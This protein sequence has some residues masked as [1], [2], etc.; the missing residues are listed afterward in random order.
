MPR[1][2]CFTF[3]LVLGCTELIAPISGGVVPCASPGDC[4]A[5]ERCH[6]G[7]CLQSTDPR[8]G[9]GRV[10]EELQPGEAGYEACDDGN[11]SDLDAC[12]TLCQLA[13]C[14]DGFARIDLPEG[15]PGAEECDDGNQANTDDCNNA[16]RRSRCGDGIVRSDLDSS[17]SDYEECD[18]DNSIATDSCTN[19]CE[20]AHCGDG[21]VRT[22]RG[23]ED[24]GYEVCDDGNDEDR[25]ACTNGCQIAFCGD[26]I[27]R[28]DLPEG[29]EGSEAC[30]DGDQEDLDD[31]NNNCV[32]TYCGDGVVQLGEA[33]DDGNRIDDDEC[34]VACGVGPIQL[35]ATNSR[36]DANYC[37]RTEDGRIYCWGQNGSGQVGQGDQQER[38]WAHEVPGITTATQ[39][40]SGDGH[41]CVILE[42]GG[43]EC[44][45]QHGYH[46]EQGRG[47]GVNAALPGPILLAPN[48][49][50]PA[51][52]GNGITDE[53]EACDDGNDINTDPCT[54]Q[55]QLNRCGDGWLGPGEA[56]DDGNDDEQDA[57]RSCR[58][59]TCGD[60]IVQEGEACDD[61]DNNSDRS[62]CTTRCTL[63]VCG[64][65][66]R[67]SGDE[68]GGATNE[69]CDDGNHVDTDACLN[70]CTAARC[71]DG[72]RRRDKNVGN[73]GYEGCDDGNDDNLDGCSTDCKA[74]LS[75]VVA[76][77]AGNRSTCSVHGDGSV[78]C[79]GYGT[80]GRLGNR[81]V[82]P[83]HVVAAATLV[84]GMED[85][86]GVT[87]GQTHACA[88]DRSGHTYCWG[89]NEEGQLGTG[90]GINHLAPTHVANLPPVQSVVAT[91]AATCAITQGAEVY[92]WG[93]Q[94]H[95]P[96]R[97]MTTRPR[98]VLVPELQGATALKA[99]GAMAYGSISG[100]WYAFFE[101]GSV[102]AW[103]GNDEA[104]ET[105]PLL[106]NANLDIVGVRDLGLAE[107]MCTLGRDYLVRCD[108]LNW[109]T[110]YA[111][112]G[113]GEPQH[114][115]SPRRLENLPPIRTSHGT[116]LTHCAVDQSDHL[117]CWGADLPN[118]GTVGDGV[119]RNGGLAPFNNLSG[120]LDVDMIH[121][122][123]CAVLLDGSVWCWG[124]GALGRPE[125]ETSL[126]LPRP[127]FDIE[128]AIGVSTSAEHA[129]ALLADGTAK[130]W[131]HNEAGQCGFNGTNPEVPG[132]IIFENG[133]PLDDLVAVRAG[134]GVSCGLRADGSLWCW[135]SNHN[136]TFGVMTE[137]DPNAIQSSLFPRQVMDLPSARAFDLSAFP[138]ALLASD[139]VTCWGRVSD[140]YGGRY[141]GTGSL[142]F[143]PIRQLVNAEQMCVGFAFGCVRHTN[144]RVSC[145]GL[146]TLG[147]GDGPRE[148]SLPLPLDGLEG[149]TDL[150]CGRGQSSGWACATNEAGEVHCWGD[151]PLP[152]TAAWR[153]HDHV[154]GIN[155]TFPEPD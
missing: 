131:G 46:G 76:A 39:L 149:V 96:A 5:G 41:F 142:G 132:L 112:P 58:L 152:K 105:L 101:D 100:R 21:I 84:V 10:R 35:V 29:S 20:V 64:D 150:R 6:E 82:R 106:R 47:S 118:R 75:D 44:W 116:G 139:Q 74:I 138:C 63:A 137:N 120:V 124:W 148:S 94:N 135:G 50:P 79:W 18:D 78:R 14:G 115:Y 4:G 45:G 90:D 54:N 61:G 59:P 49:D 56:C 25:D 37:V 140:G 88:W 30:D 123:G 128:Y 1:L 53:G 92:C 86:V 27:A 141:G 109:L 17:H 145:W 144:G 7:F 77:D 99:T 87:T 19:Q 36:Y 68:D 89:R 83:N 108:A 81:D 104:I 125:D 95:D 113:H 34:S 107:S 12:T 80:Y 102:R 31:C 23:P 71:G 28:I 70:A 121:S 93:H 9:D 119:G 65:G 98:P 13:V 122:H 117:H 134:S 42:G 24:S 129:C 155:E 146:G 97:P 15:Q 32:G 48:P 130:C 57:C 33:C 66:H 60:G 111:R 103:P 40:I 62:R 110:D 8:C 69:N 154:R 91:A 55:C 143:E 26:G 147:Q 67:F 126:Q 127:V 52:C 114:H 43:F 3:S 38:P 136:W 11:D 2:L 73:V 85:A 22:D 151:T 51:A 153:P 16:C 72:V 133:E